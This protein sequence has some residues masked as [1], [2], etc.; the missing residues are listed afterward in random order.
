LKKEPEASITLLKQQ[1]INLCKKY[2]F[3][4]NLT[5]H[6]CDEAM[7]DPQNFLTSPRTGT[8]LSAK[9]RLSCGARKIK[10][11]KTH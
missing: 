4:S 9:N 7:I 1:A 5:V 6:A 10:H 8:R 2:D 11:E 3:R